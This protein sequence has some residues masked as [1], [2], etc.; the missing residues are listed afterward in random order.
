MA[1]L[2]SLAEALP[3]DG[4][5]TGAGGSRM[6]RGIAL[7][8]QANVK[9]NLIQ[10]K[11]MKSRP[12][13]MKRRERVDRSERERFARNLAEMNGNAGSMVTGEIDVGHETE[14]QGHSRWRALR[15]FISQ[16]MEQKPG[17]QE[18]KS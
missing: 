18:L 6:Q 8:E 4:D 11:S 15:N 16:T 5:E 7:R 12:G 9:A 13:A 17:I 10:R 14:Q 2:E 3:L 1:N